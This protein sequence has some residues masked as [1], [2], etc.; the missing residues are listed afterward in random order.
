MLVGVVLVCRS[1][2]VVDGAGVEKLPSTTRFRIECWRKIEERYR[3]FALGQCRK[4]PYRQAERRQTNGRPASFQYFSS[5]NSN[6]HDPSLRAVYLS[7]R[8]YRRA[9]N[10]T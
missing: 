4:S 1:D 3:H 2:E 10:F 9:G 7:E 6:G 8:S 5:R